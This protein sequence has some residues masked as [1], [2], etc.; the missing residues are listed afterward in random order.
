MAHI[1]IKHN[2]FIITS[3]YYGKQ[4]KNVDDQAEMGV[5]FLPSIKGVIGKLQRTLEESVYSIGLKLGWWHLH[6]TVKHYPERYHIFLSNYN[7]AFQNL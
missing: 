6:P 5:L 7:H 2:Y 4:Q 1:S 3:L